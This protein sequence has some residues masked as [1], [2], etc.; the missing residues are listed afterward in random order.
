MQSRTLLHK[1]VALPSRIL[2]N[3]SIS[4]NNI[5][6]TVQRYFKRFFCR[7]GKESRIDSLPYIYRPESI[8]SITFEMNYFC[9]ANRVKG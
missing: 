7:A 3:G 1:S 9:H 6:Q 2:F 4:N 8:T 5:I